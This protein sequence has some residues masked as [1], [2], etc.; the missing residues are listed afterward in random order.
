MPLTGH[1]AE[2]RKRI[3]YSLAAV[4]AGTVLCLFFIQN[5]IS[6]LTAPAGH[7]YF[8]RP[9]E[10]FVIYM[11]T[12]LIAGF[13]L[14]SP[15]VF[16]QFWRF[17]LPAMTDREK[18][19]TL[20]FVPLSVSL[21]LGG[22][23]FSYFLVMPQSLHFLM[24]FGGENF[25]PLLSMESYLEFVLLL[26]LPFGV[27]F[28][29]PLLMMALA[30]AGLVKEKTLKRGRKF[31]ILAAFILAAVITP[32]PDILNQSLL[33]LPAVFFYEISLHVIGIMEKAHHRKES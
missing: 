22:I 5:L 16:F 32:T 19:W 7:L 12:A 27:M 3:L 29:L 17:I 10:V 11:K 15:V 33:A 25:T 13:I 9:A 23:A 28:N 1:L 8:A 2:L 30:L 26:I 4:L 6:L 21:F 14:A 31:V 24:A 18:T 20:F